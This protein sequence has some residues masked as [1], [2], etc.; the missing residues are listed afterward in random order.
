MPENPAQA[1]WTLA[2]G[3]GALREEAL[4]A[5]GANEVR[6]RTLF[7]AISR[8]TE[9]L[10]FRGL[11]PESEFERMRAPFQ[12]G[13]FPAP[14][15]Y[16]YASVGVVEHGSGEVAEPLLGRPV[17]CLYPHQT[18][19]VVPAGAVVP[20]PEGLPPA[21]A[22]LAANMETAV[23][24][25]W[26]TAP[27]VGDRIA[28]IGAGVVGA[29]AAWLCARIPATRVEL[30]DIDP[31]RAALAAALGLSL[32]TP[33]T[34]SAECDRVIHA[35]GNP[36]GLRTALRLA[37]REATVIELSWYGEQDVALPLGEAFH[38]RRLTIRSSQVGSI[39]PE[40]APRWNHRRRMEVALSLL[41]DPC[42]DALISGESAFAE[43]P[44]LMPRL[45]SDP[46]GT[47]CHR[48]RYPDA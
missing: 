26:D 27:A 6:V 32:R 35:S 36:A 37:G 2:P 43:L 16:G 13:R 19:Y 33:E 34:A 48:I 40:R 1:F 10:V 41:V 14:V 21:R 12:A 5:T 23:N 39:P 24:A 46:A 25:A 29:M 42:F 15:K 9:S 4:P 30:V 47:L 7:S 31:G 8:G 22:V 11:V 38:S 18:R 44:E 20:L 45:A 3:H 17:F 28:V